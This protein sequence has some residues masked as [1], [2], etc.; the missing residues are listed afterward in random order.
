MTIRTKRRICAAISL[1]G[2]LTLL[3]SVGGLDIG[4]LPLGKGITLAVIGLVVFA[5]A[6]YKGGYFKW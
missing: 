4:S 1:L 5:A 6:G 2:F 3:G